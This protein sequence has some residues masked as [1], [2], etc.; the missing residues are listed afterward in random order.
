MKKNSVFRLIFVFILFI[1]GLSFSQDE[2]DKMES[3]VL[4]LKSHIGSSNWNEAEPLARKLVARDPN[5]PDYNFY[6]GF[7]LNNKG[8]SGKSIEFFKTAIQLKPDYLECYD[9][10]AIVYQNMNKYD[11]AF[12]YID[13]ALNIAPDSPALLYRKGV[14]LFG[15]QKYDDSINYL[16]RSLDI[17]PQNENAVRAL[18]IA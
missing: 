6:L 9:Q 7:V 13:Q 18:L 8:E 17:A 1:A 4:L 2:K 15:A 10:L 11:E 12:E 5:N 14:L 16:K 3:F